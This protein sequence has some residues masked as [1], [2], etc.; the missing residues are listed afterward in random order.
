MC[1]TESPMRPY[2][3]KAARVFPTYVQWLKN[4]SYHQKGLYC[5]DEA[6]RV[7]AAWR[8]INKGN[9]EMR[10]ALAALVLKASESSVNVVARGF[11]RGQQI[12]LDAVVAIAAEP[13]PMPLLSSVARQFDGAIRQG[14][15]TTLQQH[16]LVP[17]GPSE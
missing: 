5:T 3:G 14:F 10:Q 1:E 15:R 16:R 11:E 6:C 13:T 17:F 12:A 8:A 9:Q 4:D 2:T 7:C